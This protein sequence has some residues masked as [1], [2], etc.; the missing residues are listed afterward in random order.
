MVSK[1][2]KQAEQLR[3]AAAQ[4]EAREK[5]AGQARMTS[6]MRVIEELRVTA[7]AVA[8]A[9]ALSA[10]GAASVATNLVLECDAMLVSRLVGSTDVLIEAGASM[11]TVDV[12]GQY[13]VCSQWTWQVSCSQQTSTVHSIIR[14]TNFWFTGRAIGALLY[15]MQVLRLCILFYVEKME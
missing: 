5:Q 14:A 3:M 15:P 6:R 13:R 10:V 7:I 11:I 4:V 1:E 8:K 12:A 2:E 9:A